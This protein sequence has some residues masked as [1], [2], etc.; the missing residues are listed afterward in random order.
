MR[1]VFLAALILLAPLQEARSIAL[2]DLPVQLQACIGT[3]TCS[4]DTSSPVASMGSMEAYRFTDT[5][6]G[7]PVTGY[8]LR[9]TLQAPSAMNESSFESEAITPYSGHVWLTM[10]DSYDLAGDVNLMTIY[11]DTVNPA[12]ANSLFL[13]DSTGLDLTVEMSSAALLAGAGSRS[14]TFDDIFSGNGLGQGN[15]DLIADTGFYSRSALAPCA[16]E[17]CYA[18]ALL[19]LVYV[20]YVDQGNGTASIA[21]N[22]DDPRAL[23]YELDVGFVNPFDV[24]FFARRQSYYVAPVPLPATA[25]LLL[26]GVALLALRT[27]RFRG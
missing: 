6:A 8:A 19:N 13:A 25:W 12:P 18:T 26:S 23:L 21:F 1:R 15:M 9:Y 17:G 14:V 24:D 27:R 2:A 10:Q 22:P 5:L 4:V 20:E 16:A 7:L 11:T 3:G